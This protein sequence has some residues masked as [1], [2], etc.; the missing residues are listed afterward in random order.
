V[1]QDTGC[2]A[3]HAQHAADTRESELYGQFTSIGGTAV[4]AQKTEAAAHRAQ[5]GSFAFAAMLSYSFVELA[6]MISCGE[7]WKRCSRGGEWAGVG[8]GWEGG[9]MAIHPRTSSVH[10]FHS[11]TERER[12]LALNYRLG[13][14]ATEHVG[15]LGGLRA[16]ANLSVAGQTGWILAGLA[17]N[18]VFGALPEPDLNQLIRRGRIETY[19]GGVIVFRKGEPAND[20]MMVL[21]GRIRLSSVSRQGR[22]VLF[23]LIG[24]GRF[25]GEV[26]LIEG[27]IRK[28]DARA[29]KASAVFMLGRPDVLACLEAHP[30]IAVRTV[31]LLCARLSRA[32]EMLEERTQLGLSSRSARAV[33]RLASEY[34]DGTRINVKISHTEIAGLVGATRENA[35]RQLCAW[36]R[37]G[38]LAF[39]EGHLVILD[40]SALRA[41]AEED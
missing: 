13:G 29:A 6:D 7:I 8:N 15:P 4:I 27:A 26:A 1:I 11:G 34:G 12:H 28:L 2:D 31:H 36:C 24:P 22:E 16:N 38:I 5:A 14:R 21:N 18:E 17:A 25:F 33:L 32:M 10:T 30:K 40:Q 37:S 20:L 3:G 35:N 9:S 23:D 19:P 39:D 41:I